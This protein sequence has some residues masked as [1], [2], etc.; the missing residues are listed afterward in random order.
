MK[1]HTLKSIFENIK[2][3]KLTME[4]IGDE[5]VIFSNI[6]F[7][8]RLVTDGSLFFA[9]SGNDC[10]GHKFVE[11]AFKKGAVAC[12]VEDSSKVEGKTGIVVNN[13]RY[14]LSVI[15]DY[16][17]E[18]PSKEDMLLFGVTGTNGKTTTNWMIHQLLTL[19]GRKPIRFGTLGIYGEG[20]ID[21]IEEDTFTTNDP[22]K[23]NTTLK[24]GKENGFDS[25]VFE[26]TSHG[27]VQDRATHLIYDCAIFTQLS[28]DHLDYH[29]TMDEYYL[30]K[31]KLFKLTQKCGGKFV[32]F[33]DDE[34]GKK[35]LEDFSD[36][37]ENTLTFGKAEDADARLLSSSSSFAGS[38]F[39]I[40]YKGEE[41]IG[42]SCFI[43][44][45]N[46]WNAVAAILSLVSQGYDMAEVVNK[47]SKV[48]PTPGRLESVGNEKIGV[49]VDMA[50][51]EDA[52]KN[53][54][55]AVRELPINNLW[56]VF[57]CGGDRDP[58]RRPGMG[59]A[60]ME[61]ADCNVLTSDNPRTE[62]IEDIFKHVLA[63]GI[64]PK[65]VEQ[66]RSIAIKYAIQ[67]AEPG[68]AVLIV[69]KGQQQF[70]DFGN[71]KFHFSDQEEGRK[72]ANEFHS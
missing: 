55:I 35:L 49:Y 58:G 38:E 14:A 15:A 8:S 1:N 59:R 71:G 47:F 16:I 39:K 10:D 24:E 50:Y 67:N 57:G 54:C 6:Q 30:A 48:K 66:D 68:D 26:I 56:L 21:E 46:V 11:E 17:Y 23:I 20:W 51:T 63:C 31:T 12:V 2:S 65:L 25:S 69:G 5:N 43:G 53:S 33:A 13:S 32:I 3:D 36:Y 9:I 29:K 64:K 28:E 7:D 72:W 4:I 40:L 45:Y 18:A 34:Y 27:L 70:Q 41:Y 60:A 44:E 19:L 42:K 52:V 61:Y 37:R 22:I 62:D